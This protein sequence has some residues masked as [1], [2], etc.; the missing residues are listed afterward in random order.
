MHQIE[1]LVK[2]G[3]TDVILAVSYQSDV[4][5]SYLGEKAKELGINIIISK[6]D[7]PL[8]TA[9][10]LSLAREHLYGPDPFFVLNS[11]VSCE[12]PFQELLEFHMA[13]GKEGTIFVTQVKDPSKYGVV[14]A[15]DN[16]CISRFVEKP[17]E[18]VGDKINAGMYVF[19]K[20]ILDRIK[21]VPTSIEREIFP[22][23]AEEGNLYRYVLP[24][25]WMD[26]GQPPD[27]LKGQVM[28]LDSVANRKSD[29]GESPKRRK[30]EG[31]LATGSHIVGNVI[32]HP[33]AKIGANCKI[34]PRRD[35]R[36]LHYW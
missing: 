35:W 26:I 23:M 34:G 27:Y 9:G 28:Y 33:T 17:K 5:A 6:E 22:A 19:N 29:N 4:M 2:V 18:F 7:E 1:A 30:T 10:P 21:P 32:I 20:E 8:G 14:V 12:Y 24:G 15:K 31:E 16:G 3:V 13:H 25:F 36:K 11:D